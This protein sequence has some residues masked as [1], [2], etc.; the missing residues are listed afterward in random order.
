M[1]SLTSEPSK[2]CLGAV[3]REDSATQPDSP[4]SVNCT[5]GW[6]SNESD[7]CRQ[8]MLRGSQALLE[9]MREEGLA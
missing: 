3:S 1:N 2:F 5:R 4:Y 6:I 8:I 7:A 9:Q